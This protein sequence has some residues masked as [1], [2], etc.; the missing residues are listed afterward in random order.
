[1]SSK[2][3]SARIVPRND[4]EVQESQSPIQG[5]FESHLRKSK[6][7]VCTLGYGRNE[8]ASLFD[9]KVDVAFSDLQRWLATYC[10]N[11]TEIKG[12]SY[13]TVR[14]AMGLDLRYNSF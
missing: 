7:H 14:S 8:G 1:M 9:E 11:V 4:V 13:S 6:G 5:T 12:S 3:F 2:N 10:V